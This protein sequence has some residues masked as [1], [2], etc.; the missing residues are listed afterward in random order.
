MKLHDVPPTSQTS[1]SGMLS[2]RKNAGSRRLLA[3]LP[4]Y[5]DS[6]INMLD[7]AP[8]TPCGPREFASDPETFIRLDSETIPTG[9]RVHQCW[10]DARSFLISRSSPHALLVMVRMRRYFVSC[11]QLRLNGL[12]PIRFYRLPLEKPLNHHASRSLRV[13]VRAGGIPPEST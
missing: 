6:G 3:G 10:V 11:V 5:A 8:R 2:E 9:K 13:R 12:M 4:R 1:S 7:S